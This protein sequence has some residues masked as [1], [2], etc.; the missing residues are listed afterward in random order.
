MALQKGYHE[1]LI[2]L[3]NGDDTI[4]RSVAIMSIA[5]LSESGNHFLLFLL[6]TLLEEG[7]LVLSR[8]N[9]FQKIYDLVYVPWED[10]DFTLSNDGK[11]LPIRVLT[12]FC[13][14]A[15]C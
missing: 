6:F 11:M 10:P 7:K 4:L 14:L 13:Q 1:K 2:Q 15:N 5:K 8:T 12:I 3:L 9:A